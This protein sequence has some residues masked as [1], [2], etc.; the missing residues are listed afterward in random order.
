MALPTMHLGEHVVADYQTIRLSLKTHPMALLRPVFRAER[1]LSCAELMLAKAGARVAV[2]GFVLVRQRPG[3]GKAIFVTLEDES[4]VANIIMWARTF[5]TQRR[6][7]MASRLMQVSGE[8]QRSPEGIVH[9]MAHRIT[10]RNAEI[11]RL[12][13]QRRLD[14]QLSRADEF[15]HPQHQRVRHPRDVRIFPKSRD[16][17]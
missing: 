4:G 12:S 14:P 15:A 11:E 16:F 5:E 8:V 7:V 17:H 9:L 10:E 3:N 1:V 2:A 6:A 13:D